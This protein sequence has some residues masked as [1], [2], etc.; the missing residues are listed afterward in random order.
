MDYII[1]SESFT[2]NSSLY[3]FTNYRIAVTAVTG[4]GVLVAGLIYIIICLHTRMD[5]L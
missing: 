2:V 1:E 5:D 3:N 4:I